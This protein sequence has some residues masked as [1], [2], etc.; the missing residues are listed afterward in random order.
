MYILYIFA[1][2]TFRTLNE[3]IALHTNMVQYTYNV[4][5]ALNTNAVPRC[6]G[7]SKRNAL[8]TIFS[9]FSFVSFS[10]LPLKGRGQEMDFKKFDNNGQFWA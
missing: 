4:K 5:Y 7:S 3:K 10:A 2:Y 8:K 1:H 9:Y 6:V